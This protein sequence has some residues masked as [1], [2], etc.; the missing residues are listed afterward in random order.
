MSSR[1]PLSF[2]EAYWQGTFITN[3]ANEELPVVERVLNNPD[4]IKE[5]LGVYVEKVAYDFEGKV[6]DNAASLHSKDKKSMTTFW[7][8]FTKTQDKMKRKYNDF[9]N[10]MKE[11]V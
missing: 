2:N 4:V 9:G 1:K 5:E 6:I 11:D 8:V 10:V 7:K 3:I